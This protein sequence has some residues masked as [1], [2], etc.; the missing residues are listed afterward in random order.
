MALTSV[1]RAQILT[2]QAGYIALK[3]LRIDRERDGYAQFLFDLKDPKYNQKGTHWSLTTGLL[4]ITPEGL[5]DRNT[6]AEVEAIYHGLL[7][8]RS[9]C[10]RP[11]SVVPQALEVSSNPAQLPDGKGYGVSIK[12][13]GKNGA[14]S[15]VDPVLLLQAN[16]GSLKVLMIKRFDGSRA[17]PGGMQE[18]NVLNT[19]IQE[20]LEEVFS[21][22]LFAQESATAQAI[23]EQ[24]TQ[25]IEQ[26]VVGLINNNE[27]FKKLRPHVRQ[28]QEDTEEAINPAAYI[29]Q[30]CKSIDAIKELDAHTSTISI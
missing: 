28:L 27:D 8:E 16:D 2:Q 29:R 11:N 23:H 12:L 13:L 22:D 14:N 1:E 18:S 3:K 21:D 30:L 17:F 20:L 4:N 15:A 19:C 26:V 25:H 9:W 24:K 5:R 7:S 10:Q 6:L